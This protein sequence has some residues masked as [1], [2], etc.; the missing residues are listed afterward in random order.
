MIIPSTDSTLRPIKLLS[1]I[2]NC[3]ISLAVI[4]CGST[5]RSRKGTK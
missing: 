5:T 2:L 1:T 4:Q 3:I